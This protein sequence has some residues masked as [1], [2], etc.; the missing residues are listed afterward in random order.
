M[1]YS[2]PAVPQAPPEFQVHIFAAFPRGANVGNTAENHEISKL[3]LGPSTEAWPGSHLTLQSCPRS[4]LCLQYD[5]FLSN[6]AEMFGDL[7]L[8]RPSIVCEQSM[9]S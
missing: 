3:S 1:R 9:L 8:N 2:D 6:I 5:R 4:L 7:H